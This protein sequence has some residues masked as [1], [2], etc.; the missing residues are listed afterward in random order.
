LAIIWHAKHDQ[1]GIRFCDLR[2]VILTK[3]TLNEHNQPTSLEPRKVINDA[4]KDTSGSL[5]KKLEQDLG[6]MLKESEKGGEPDPWQLLGLEQTISDDAYRKDL[7]EFIG[8]L[9][10]AKA[11]APYV[12]RGLIVN[13]R[14]QDL[15]TYAK[16]VEAKFLDE[17]SCPGAAELTNVEKESLRRKVSGDISP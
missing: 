12:A 14:L 1:S 8:E 6:S 11:D 13:K 5:M 10:C 4:V 15:G 9:G 7:A 16:M 17:K 3:S 2:S